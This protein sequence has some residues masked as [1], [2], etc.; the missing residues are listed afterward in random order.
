[1]TLVVRQT[2][3]DICE[4][5]SV[6]PGT[7]AGD[8]PKNVIPHQQFKFTERTDLLKTAGN[9][10]FNISLYTLDT[11]YGK[12][13]M[14][15]FKRKGT[16]RLVRCIRR[17]G[18]SDWLEGFSSARVMSAQGVERGHGP[19]LFVRS[20]ST[21]TLRKEVGFL[22]RQTILFSNKVAEGSL[23]VSWLLQIH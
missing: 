6:C 8:A 14:F 17:F 12:W 18:K 11:H 19:T 2:T 10:K 15:S 9:Q 20:C 21:Y 22:A 16:K 4:Y 13:G 1:M 7:F 3:K 5:V 23:S